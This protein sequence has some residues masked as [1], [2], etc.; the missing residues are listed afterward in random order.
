MTRSNKLLKT[1]S[2]K[3]IKASGN[4]L[5]PVDLP[6]GR[7]LHESGKKIT[8]VY[9]PAV[10]V[11]S[12]VNEPTPGQVVEVATIGNEGMVG[13]PI[14]LGV[15]SMPSRAF[16]QVPGNGF[17]L[18]TREFRKLLKREPKFHKLLLRYNL[19][20]LNQIAQSVSCNRL[21][22]VHERCARW[23]LQ[24]HDRVEGDVFQLTQ[25]F[26]GQMLGVHR[27]TVSVAAGMLQRAGMIDYSRGT[28]TIRDR[29]G[30]E[31]ASCPCYKI[32]VRDYER[33]LKA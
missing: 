10:G 26:L 17:R 6:L 24:T 19:A 22:E 1:L 16:M 32:I 13:L 29:K 4:A 30:L 12:I 9:F 3:S 28:I 33:L 11:A 20:V 18:T 15:E 5:E 23:L 14:L 8:H 7:V 27:P 21:H 31:K 2:A 25:E